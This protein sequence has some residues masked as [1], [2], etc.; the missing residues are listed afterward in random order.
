MRSWLQITLLCAGAMAIGK[1]MPVPA[2]QPDKAAAVDLEGNALPVGSLARFGSISFYHEHGVKV[3]Y[4][5]DGKILA[6]SGGRVIRLWDPATGRDLGQFPGDR[7]FALSPDGTLL[8]AD[9]AFDRGLVLIWDTR[10]GKELHRLSAHHAEVFALAF[11]PDGK[12]LATGAF[13]GTIRL[14]NAVTGKQERLLAENKG[15]VSALAFSRDGK[16]LFLGSIFLGPMAECRTQAGT[17]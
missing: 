5:G 7:G 1:G 17:A 13:D 3:A 12:Q 15:Y 10:S 2:S 8:A 9:A 6:S 14:W 4:S 16:T 11:S